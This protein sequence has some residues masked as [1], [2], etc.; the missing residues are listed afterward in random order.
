LSIDSQTDK[1]FAPKDNARDK[2][3]GEGV[4]SARSSCSLQGYK[5]C[6]VFPPVRKLSSVRTLRFI[7][8]WTTIECKTRQNRN[9]ENVGK[10]KN[11]LVLFEDF[12]KLQ[13]CGFNHD[14]LTKV[15]DVKQDI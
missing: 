3:S 13:T 7:G 5:P 10:G 4:S 9:E 11:Y 15:L 12:C 2:L 8:F 14:R 6:L 1:A